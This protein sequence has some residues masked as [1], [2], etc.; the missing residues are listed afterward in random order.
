MTKGQRG[1]FAIGIF[2]PKKSVNVGTLW[3]TANILGAAYIFTIGARYSKQCSDT[4]KTHRHIPLVYYDDF[5]DCYRH[6]PYDAQLVAVELTEEARDLYSFTHPE[7]AVY[8][9]GAED[10]GLPQDIVERCH[11]VIKL[12]GEFS[13]NVS[14]AGSIC[15]YHRVETMG[16]QDVV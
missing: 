4:M 2:N 9:L 8:L 7:R 16:Q 13:L 6:L 3:R 10:H 14:V 5:E 1:Y 15:L 11:H 12:R